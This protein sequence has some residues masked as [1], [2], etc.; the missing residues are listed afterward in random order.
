MLSPLCVPSHPGGDSPHFPSVSPCSQGALSLSCCW[1]LGLH[2]SHFPSSWSPIQAWR[3][4]P[5]WHMAVC[6]PMVLAAVLNRTVPHR[7]SLGAV[8]ALWLVRPHGKMVGGVRR[9][10]L[11]IFMVHLNV[12]TKY[13]GMSTDCWPGIE[14]H[15]SL[16]FPFRRTSRSSLPIS[17]GSIVAHGPRVRWRYTSS[18]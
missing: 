6:S 12:S 10:S 18:S 11:S 17:Q 14:N 15:S 7:A 1:L 13:Y 2:S 16:G 3:T 5:W 9:A 8:A 4:S